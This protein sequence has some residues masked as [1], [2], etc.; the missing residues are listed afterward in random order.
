MTSFEDV[1]RLTKQLALYFGRQSID[2][3]SLLVATNFLVPDDE[4]HFLRNEVTRR[5]HPNAPST[6]KIL[7]DADKESKDNK[8][9]PGT[10]A[11][12]RGGAAIIA[13]YSTRVRLQIAPEVTDLATVFSTTRDGGRFT[14]ADT[15]PLSPEDTQAINRWSASLGG[16][17]AFDNTSDTGIVHDLRCALDNLW[18][19]SRLPGQG[20]SEIFSIPAN[21][22]KL[23]D[24]ARAETTLKRLQQE[25]A[26]DLLGQPQAARLMLERLYMQHWGLSSGSGPM[27]FL[28]MGPPST[29]KSLM[30]DILV[31]ALT[32]RPC[33]TLNMSSFQ[34]EN[35]AFGLTGLRRGYTNAGPGR[36][37]GFVHENPRAVIVFDKIEDAHAKV[38]DILVPMLSEGYLTDE[39]G[40]GTD[41][42]TWNRDTSRV[43]FADTIVIFTTTLGH[44]VYDRPDFISLYNTTPHTAIAQLRAALS[45]SDQPQRQISPHLGSYMGMLSLLP[46][47]PLSMDVYLSLARKRLD[48]MTSSLRRDGV[49]LVVPDTNRLAWLLVTATGPAFNASELAREADAPL[50][51]AFVADA[52]SAAIAAAQ[53]KSAGGETTPPPAGAGAA[54]LLEVMIEPSATLD[55]LVS[56]EGDDMIRRFYRRGEVLRYTLNTERRGERLIL[57]FSNISLGRVVMGDNYGDTGR[58][59]IT[60]PEQKFADIYGHEAVKERLAFIASI[61]G[62]IDRG[63]T[64]GLP[65]ALPRGMLLSGR[66]G[67]GK[68]MLARALAAEAEVPFIAVTGPEFFSLE[69][70]RDVFARARKFAPSIVFIDEI[71]ALGV[72]GRD[73]VDPCINQL[74]TE[75]DGAETVK[76][77]QVFVIAATN[78]PSR[79]DPA[80]TRSGRLDIKVDVPCLDREARRHFLE[81]FARLP[82]DSTWNEEELLDLTAGMSG[83]DLGRV[84]REV[85]LEQLGS[86]HTEI[87]Q[88][89]VIEQINVVKYGERAPANQ[90]RARLEATAYHEAGHTV[91]AYVLTPWRRVEQVSI[92]PRGDTLGVTCYTS[93]GGGID[94][95]RS[96]VLSGMAV[97]LAGRLSEMRFAASR[98]HNA[99]E[100]INEAEMDGRNSGASTDL[101]SACGMAWQAV[102][103]WGLDDEFGSAPLA[104][105]TE[106][107]AAMFAAPARLRVATWME[108]ASKRAQAVLDA[109]WSAVEEIAHLLLSDTMLTYRTIQNIMN[110]AGR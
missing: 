66:P 84:R 69:L 104:P 86:Q 18:A 91:V 53:T 72:R 98:P 75:I 31:K 63:E 49:E 36:L 93:E 57:T 52:M 25:L 10:S 80:L 105:L 101:A 4:W 58:F 5:L 33:L 20:E 110:K 26:D 21:E 85:L 99:G 29:G 68:T 65:T 62:R 95:D 24:A 7:S 1:L 74:L 76:G 27:G 39:Y 9:T 102:T 73:G 106:E 67:T 30:V 107:A 82:H 59:E 71:D 56:S 13:E 97:A 96:A 55:T 2:L 108:E 42:K 54:R 22:D 88:A 11:S 43:S 23:D 100:S 77:E 50:S 83:A 3:K 103:Q 8:N 70:I 51:R 41:K 47:R 15:P 61:L 109:R 44:T 37:T 16:D 35:E 38:Q 79:V 12:L 90:L 94:M 89:E 28:L 48:N 6:D 92:V 78:F 19:Q 60:L 64:A 46:F 45:S 81:Q 34:S 14:L 40:F 32:D 17:N 87:S